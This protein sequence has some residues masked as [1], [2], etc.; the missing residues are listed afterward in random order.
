MT[1]RSRRK[2]KATFRLIN[3]STKW[4]GNGYS[5]N[6]F[7]GAQVLYMLYTRH[8]HSV[9]IYS[10]HCRLNI[11]I[12]SIRFQ[13]ISFRFPI[14]FDSIGRGKCLSFATKFLCSSWDLLPLLIA[15]SLSFIVQRVVAIII[16]SRSS[17]D[18][19]SVVDAVVSSLSLYHVIWDMWTGSKRRDKNW[20]F[21][22]VLVL[23][24]A[25]FKNVFSLFP[26][27]LSFSLVK[28][29]HTHTC[30]E[31]TGDSLKLPTLQYF[32]RL[33]LLFGL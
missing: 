31:R 3:S 4:N 5:F 16:N 22:S 13:F 23:I 20:L 14:A 8:S 21:I 25:P 12:N 7:R 24:S 15:K 33:C 2:R 18:S 28:H 10:S 30:K 9:S 19:N 26:R 11:F 17:S 29:T 6:T 27:I 1:C 32:L